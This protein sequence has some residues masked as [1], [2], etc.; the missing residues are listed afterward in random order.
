MPV[1][2]GSGLVLNQTEDELVKQTKSLIGQGFRAVKV[3][4]GKPTVEEDERRLDAVVSELPD[5]A[6]LILDAV[7]GWSPEVAIRRSRRFERYQP[8]W[9]ED[10]LVHNDYPGLARVV[11]ASPIPIATGENEYLREGFH[12]L[13]EIGVP[14]LLADLERVGGI[15]EWEAVAGAASMRSSVLTPHCYPHVA[16]QLCSTLQQNQTWIEYVPFWDG[17]MRQQFDFSKGSISVPTTPG[18]GWDFDDRAVDRHAVAP[19]DSL[20]APSPV[21]YLGGDRNRD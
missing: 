16:V 14:Y 11:N 7:Q 8:L 9:L 18:I 12:Q 13:L 15:L 5:G 4:V 20:L 3:R 10:P 21:V 1:Y 6:V 2:W 17:L 19:W